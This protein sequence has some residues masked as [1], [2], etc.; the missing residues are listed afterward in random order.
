MQSRRFFIAFLLIA[1]LHRAYATDEI[2]VPPE[3]TPE[4][5]L[6][7]SAE[8]TEDNGI[9][10]PKA[11]TLINSYG[12]ITPVTEMEDKSPYQ[13]AQEELVRSHELLESSDFEAA[14]DTALVAYDDFNGM[15]R[16]PGVQRTKIRSQAHEAA[17]VYV[18]ASIVAASDHSTTALEEARGRL[19]DLRDVARNYLELNKKLNKAINDL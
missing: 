11:D 15:P 1:G 13:Q 3:N 5:P 19:E 18:D 9:I 17:K 4:P 8:D 6:S 10:P 7:T 12:P 2:V 14:S 16:V